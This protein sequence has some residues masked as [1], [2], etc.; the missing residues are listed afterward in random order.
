MAI[1]YKTEY[2]K[3]KRYYTQF[4]KLYTSRKEVRAYVN[5]GFA[6]LA[7]AFFTTFAIR[8]ALTTIASLWSE[9]KSQEEI[10]K[11]LSEKVEALQTAAT[12][13]S[14][15]QSRLELLNIGGAKL[16]LI[17]NFMRQIEALSAKHS[18]VVDSISFEETN[19]TGTADSTSNLANFTMSLGGSYPNLNSF[20]TDVE[21]L[22]RIVSVQSFTYSKTGALVGTIISPERSL[23]NS[24]V[25]S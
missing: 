25:K 7:L 16:P 13:F 23:G 2:Q 17:A 21:N 22:R 1:D 5:V 20:L 14:Q 15:I 3:Y 8:P 6:F 10:D 9:I 24:P 12:N 11:K 4:G 18:V 19:F